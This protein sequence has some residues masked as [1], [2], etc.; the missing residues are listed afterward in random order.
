MRVSSNAILIKN[1][2]IL[3]GKRPKTKKYFPGHWDVFGG[4]VEGKET[5]EETLKRE[6]KEELGIDVVK[7]KFFDALKNDIEPNSKEVYDHYFFIVTK[8]KGY[9]RKKNLT[10][11]KILRWISK[12]D[13]NKLKFSRSLKEI[14]RKALE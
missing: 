8:W 7:Y 6:V 9:I 2:K 4:H 1:N 12:K 14:L 3:V 5:L 10:E 13:L 11:I